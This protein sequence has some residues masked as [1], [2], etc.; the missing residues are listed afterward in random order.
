MKGELIGA[1]VNRWRGR[2]VRIFEDTE[3]RASVYT[4]GIMLLV[5][6]TCHLPGSGGRACPACKPA[7]VIHTHEPRALYARDIGTFGKVYE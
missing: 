5:Q 7:E 3:D 2:S 1:F 6:H 4:E